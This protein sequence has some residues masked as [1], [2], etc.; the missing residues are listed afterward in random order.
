MQAT[1]THST[2]LNVYNK[3]YSNEIHPGVTLFKSKG[4][5]SSF[6]YA[7]VSIQPSSAE[8]LPEPALRPGRDVS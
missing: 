7:L 2:V 1:A 5:Q 4:I 3:I 6:L 8:E